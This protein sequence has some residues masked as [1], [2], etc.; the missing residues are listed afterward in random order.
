MQADNQR[1]IAL[2]CTCGYELES[3]RRTAICLADTRADELFMAEL[4]P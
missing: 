1:A 3:T 4:D 2:S